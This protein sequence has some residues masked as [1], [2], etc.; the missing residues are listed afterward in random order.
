MAS[1]T[2]EISLL[3]GTEPYNIYLCD[4]GFTTC[5]YINT[6]NDSDITYSFPLP[7]IFSGQSKLIIKAVDS[8]N[9]SILYEINVPII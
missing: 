7:A 9:C 8:L 5:L 6:I 3:T 2:I 4:T 1:Y